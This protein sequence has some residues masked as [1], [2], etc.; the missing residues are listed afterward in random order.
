[1]QFL[2]KIKNSTNLQVRNLWTQKI[3]KSIFSASC[4]HVIG[5]I[6]HHFFAFDL[7][8]FTP[9][10]FG[11]PL[12]IRLN[13]LSIC[14]YYNQNLNFWRRFFLGIF[15]PGARQYLLLVGQAL[16]APWPYIFPGGNGIDCL[17]LRHRPRPHLPP[18]RRRHNW[19][20]GH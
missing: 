17:P 16:L 8:P 5:N 9:T 3:Q 4:Q 12:E 13:F 7:L 11:S 6:F 2:S 15:S 14:S 18:L 19:P 1:M 20:I 10:N